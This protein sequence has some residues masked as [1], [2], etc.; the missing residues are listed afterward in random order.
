MPSASA[1]PRNA[2]ATRQRLLR[3]ALEL[4][5]TEGYRATTTERIAGRAGVAEGTIY[6]HF[7]GKEELFNEA[8]RGALRWGHGLVEELAAD[9]TL[10]ARDLLD[11]LGRRLVEGAERDPPAFRMLLAAGVERH[12]DERSQGARAAFREALQQVVARGKSDGLVRP[13]PVELW[14]QVWLAVAGFVGERVSAREWAPDHPQVALALQAAWDS[15][16][17]PE[18]S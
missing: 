11:R 13:G 1:S 16:S 15:I 4:Y 14:A 9:R 12:L 6:R 8:Y 17:L 2:E 10:G 5:T 18:R 3:A 7:R